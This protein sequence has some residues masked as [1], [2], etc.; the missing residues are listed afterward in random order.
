MYENGERDSAGGKPPRV[1]RR[2]CVVLGRKL[3]VE[4]KTQTLTII[5]LKTIRKMQIPDS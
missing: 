5:K 1:A 4:V 2:Y 3:L